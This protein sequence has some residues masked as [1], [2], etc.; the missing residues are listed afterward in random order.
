MR[1]GRDRER[2]ETTRKRERDETRKRQGRD[3]PAA[4]SSSPC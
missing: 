3:L 4:K 1:Q 2:D